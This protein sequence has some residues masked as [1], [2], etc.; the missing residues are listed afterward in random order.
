MG[1]VN[2][3]MQRMFTHAITRSPGKNF[4][5]GLTT[6]T[7][8]IPSYE[9]ILKQHSAYVETLRSIGLKVTVLDPQPDY[10]DAHFVEDTAVVTSDVAI[11]TNPGADSRIGETDTIRPAL[12]HYRK[13]EHIQEPGT[14]DG[15]D[16]LMVGNHFFIGISERTNQEGAEQFGQI[17]EKFDNTW[18]AVQVDADLHLKS[19]VNYIAENTLLVTQDFA[20]HKAL[21]EYT[22]IVVNTAEAY[23]AN[24][25]WVNDH[26]LI[27]K[28]FPETKAKLNT[29]GL[30]II[31]LDVS[32]MRKMD[33]GLTCL[34]IRF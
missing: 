9:L 14:M 34:S 23:A 32:E 19:S 6:A 20:N 25:L 15:G 17:I 13:I 29:L 10:P 33:G 8:G 3:A 21:K 1:H 27:P 24:A 12:A 7:L 4:S 16:V 11:I 30:K 18:E 22:K 26:L 5:Q 28:E 31:E 2:I